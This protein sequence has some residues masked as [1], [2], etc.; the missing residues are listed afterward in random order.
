MVMWTVLIW[1]GVSCGA[2][3]GD[4]DNSAERFCEPAA[5]DSCVC[6]PD[7]EPELSECSAESVSGPALCCDDEAGGFCQ[8]TALACGQ[9]EEF[10]SCGPRAAVLREGQTEVDSCEA[11]G[12]EMACCLSPSAGAAGV[13]CTC[14]AG[15]CPAG[16]DEVD[17]CTTEV[18][19]DCGETDEVDACS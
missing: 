18:I 19:M 14:A 6:A 16:D 13:S 2:E 12:A 9:D 7:R 8:C 11:G 4:S 10:C 15:P 3:G 5:G 17:A 1:A